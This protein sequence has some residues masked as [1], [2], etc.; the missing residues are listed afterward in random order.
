MKRILIAGIGNI[1]FGDDAF[2][3]EM[4]GALRQRDLPPEVELV[5]FGIRSYDLAYA[6]SGD[7][8]AMLLL[9]AVSRGES[10]GTVYLVEPDL[11]QL[12]QL[13][14]SAVD[15][16]SLDPVR[17][18]QLAASLGHIKTLPY[19]IGCEPSTLETPDGQFG[20][21]PQVREAIPRAVELVEKLVAD[22]LHAETKTKPGLAPA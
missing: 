17:V 8:D 6:L 13:A 9:D 14:P 1:F 10:P 4:I 11:D 7:Y 12:S 19:L 16:H 3:V 20:L 18:L 15:A 5:D 2:G 22:L 21:S